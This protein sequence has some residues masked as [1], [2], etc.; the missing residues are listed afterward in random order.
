[1]WAAEGERRAPGRGGG[2]GRAP[3]KTFARSGP[4]GARSE[5]RPTRGSARGERLEEA[6]V[7]DFE[8]RGRGRG[9][10]GAVGGGRGRCI[11]RA[12]PS[13]PSLQ[14]RISER[15]DGGAAGREQGRARGRRPGPASAHRCAWGCSGGVRDG[16]PEARARAGE[17]QQPSPLSPPTPKGKQ[18][19]S[20][21]HSLGGLLGRKDLDRV[22]AREHGHLARCVV[23]V[24]LF[25]GRSCEGWLS[26]GGAGGG[27]GLHLAGL[28][29]GFSRGLFA[30]FRPTLAPATA[31]SSR[32]AHPAT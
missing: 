17:S 25:R 7:P 8:A 28:R 11:F 27:R 31:L 26:S 3:K 9:K 6:K 13:P 24:F 21:T 23:V 4:R 16:A 32:L 19:P 12:T 29:V 14:G 18:L 1:V 5:Q 2:E 10:R 30:A 22:G 20:Q 15:G